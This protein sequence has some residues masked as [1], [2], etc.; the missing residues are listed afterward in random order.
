M[1]SIRPDFLTR[2][3][4]LRTVG[5]LPLLVMIV[6]LGWGAPAGLFRDALWVNSLGWIAAGTALAYFWKRVCSPDPAQWGRIKGLLAV[7]IFKTSSRPLMS[8]I[9]SQPALT[10]PVIVRWYKYRM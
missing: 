5:V 3:S 4:V 2:P 9:F 7:W 8:V 6:V 10:G 1:S